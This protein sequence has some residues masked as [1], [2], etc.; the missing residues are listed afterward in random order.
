ML[1]FKA[2]DAR[3]TSA[4]EL[5]RRLKA[6]RFQK[7]NPKLQVNVDINCLPNAPSVVFKLVD[8]SE[9]S[10]IYIADLLF[11]QNYRT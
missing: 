2:F 1:I 7:A 6:P 8:D 9:V 4:K 3:A 5:V 10:T 11:Y